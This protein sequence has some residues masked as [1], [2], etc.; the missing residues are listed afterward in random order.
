M[1]QNKTTIKDSLNNYWNLILTSTNSTQ[2][3]RWWLNNAETTLAQLYLMIWQSTLLE[4]S[5]INQHTC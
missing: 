4:A 2:S 5:E 1:T 3:E